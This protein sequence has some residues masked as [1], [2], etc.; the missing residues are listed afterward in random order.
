MSKEKFVR[1]KVPASRIEEIASKSNSP[2]A[3]T[4]VAVCMVLET[5]EELEVQRN[6]FNL[7]QQE[8]NTN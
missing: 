4:T 7:K 1:K 6:A 8:K 3:S 2:K 5:L